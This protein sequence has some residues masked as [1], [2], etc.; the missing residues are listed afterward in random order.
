MS[1]VD[2]NFSVTHFNLK[3]FTIK[4]K[5]VIEKGWES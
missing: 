3:R 2:C 5:I 1:T 4:V